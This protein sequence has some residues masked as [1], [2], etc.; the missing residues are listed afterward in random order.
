M[1]V[2]DPLGGL[3]VHNDTEDV[4]YVR[5]FTLRKPETLQPQLTGDGALAPGMETGSA[6]GGVGGRTRRPT[7]GTAGCF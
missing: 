1:L 7:R 2:V 3:V 6:D 5:R 4:E